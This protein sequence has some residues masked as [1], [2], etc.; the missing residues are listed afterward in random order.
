MKPDSRTKW[1]VEN[2]RLYRMEVSVCL[3]TSLL[4]LSLRHGAMKAWVFSF[5]PI[6][7]QL[8]RGGQAA[9]HSREPQAAETLVNV[10]NINEVESINLEQ[11]PGE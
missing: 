9:V 1:T 2:P 8:L 7:L 3:H 10:R 4:G 5:L 11:K 6:Q